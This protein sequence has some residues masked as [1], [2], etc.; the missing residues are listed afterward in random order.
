M[1]DMES[2]I[3]QGNEGLH[4]ANSDPNLTETTTTVYSWTIDSC[5]AER[6][7]HRIGEGAAGKHRGRVT[8]R[9]GTILPRTPGSDLRAVFIL[10]ECPR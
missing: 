3:P 2:R 5:H 9:V 4:A 7:L 10:I 8:R 6:T 1:P